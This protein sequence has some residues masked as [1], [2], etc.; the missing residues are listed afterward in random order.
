MQLT[1]NLALLGNGT[2][3]AN[4]QRPATVAPVVVPCEEKQKD[5]KGEHE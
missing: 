2:R 4:N 5:V 1:A 3:R